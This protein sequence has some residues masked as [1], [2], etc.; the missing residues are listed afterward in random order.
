[1]SDQDRKDELKSTTDDNKSDSSP[2]SSPKTKGI[3]DKIV[4][5][6]SSTTTGKL[7][8]ENNVNLSESARVSNNV[9]T[10]ILGLFA[11]IGFIILVFAVFTA[12]VGA[13]LNQVQ[14][15]NSV[16][17]AAIVGAFTLVGVIVYQIR[18]SNGR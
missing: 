2:P 10:V 5:K 14:F 6:I 12:S 17:I 9:R 3:K 15:A 8:E 16:F 18:G 13:Q 11:L 4:G 7:Q 1:M